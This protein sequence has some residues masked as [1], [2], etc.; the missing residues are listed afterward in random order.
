VSAA[1]QHI[2]IEA[3]QLA[4][5]SWQYRA[6]TPALDWR[7]AQGEWTRLDNLRPLNGQLRAGGYYMVRADSDPQWALLSR[8]EV[9]LPTASRACSPAQR[10]ARAYGEANG[11]VGGPGGWIYDT[12]RK[13]APGGRRKG[14]CQGWAAFTTI[15]HRRG[16][17]VPVPGTYVPGTS[18]GSMRW[19]AS[20]AAMPAWRGSAEVPRPLCV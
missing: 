16:G 11:I 18:P 12:T 8:P 5:A 3:R 19:H 4:S 17:I 9:F 1:Q 6:V 2:V 15:A 13:V 20:W 10:A 7:T 14:I